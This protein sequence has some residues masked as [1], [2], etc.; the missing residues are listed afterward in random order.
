MYSKK[1]K[2]LVIL[3]CFLFLFVF[4]HAQTTV[5]PVT[6]VVRLDHSDWKYNIGQNALFTIAVEK[7][8]KTLKDVVVHI[9]IGPEKMQATIVKDS[10]LKKEC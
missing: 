10:L 1:H 7:D 2:G 3:C 9:E 8:G 5:L 4:V 6:A